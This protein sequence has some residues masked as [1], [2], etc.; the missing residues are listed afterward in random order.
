MV[1]LSLTGSLVRWAATGISAVVIALAIQAVLPG[2]AWADAGGS[3]EQQLSDL[4]DRLFEHEYPSDASDA[5]L[6]RLEKMVF[7]EVRGGA[8]SQRLKDLVEA[9]PK[10]AEAPAQ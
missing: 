4:E 7:G 3:V 9:V 1:R 5:R 2:G 6:E 10:P 8:V